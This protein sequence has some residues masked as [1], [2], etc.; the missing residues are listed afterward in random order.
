MHLFPWARGLR[1]FIAGLVH[2]Q[3]MYA[4]QHWHQYRG[5]MTKHEVTPHRSLW[6]FLICLLYHNAHTVYT[7]WS[8]I[9]IENK[10]KY[11]MWYA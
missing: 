11:G 9:G 4:A 1:T 10:Y 5:P 3:K 7:T 6:R 8:R 2:R